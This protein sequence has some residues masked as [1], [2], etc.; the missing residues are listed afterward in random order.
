MAK[1]ELLPPPMQQ[2]GAS[3]DNAGS[4]R[5]LPRRPRAHVVAHHTLRQIALSLGT[6][7]N[8]KSN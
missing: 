4:L 3:R 7:R 8:V 2:D 5:F 6:S 1:V